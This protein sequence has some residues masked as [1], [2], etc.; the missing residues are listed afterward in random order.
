VSS[1]FAILIELRSPSELA[2]VRSA[3]L[4]ICCRFHHSPNELLA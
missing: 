2:R 4:F 3:T 1:V